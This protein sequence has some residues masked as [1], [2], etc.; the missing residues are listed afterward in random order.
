LRVKPIFGR[1]ETLKKFGNTFHLGSRALTLLG[2]KKFVP[3]QP[4]GAE[5]EHSYKNR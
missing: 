4:V 3:T 2:F 5:D 1:L